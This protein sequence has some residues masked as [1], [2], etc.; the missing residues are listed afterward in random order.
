VDRDGDGTPDHQDNCG[1]TG[2]ILLA[3]DQA[4]DDADGI[5]DACDD[6]PFKGHM[7]AGETYFY[8][9]YD[10]PLSGFGEI[11]STLSVR[12]KTQ[13]FKQDYE[14][15]GKS[16]LTFI[17]YQATFRV[18]YKPGGGGIVSFGSVHG[19]ASYARIPWDWKGNDP[20]YPYGVKTSA[21]TV[22]FHYRGSAAVCIFSRGCGPTK[23]PWV[24]IT[25]RDNN[26]MEVDAGVV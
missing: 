21:H 23:H 5:G 22:A 17:T 24:T 2:T 3:N 18:C 11:E 26:T 4:D 9:G 13:M 25:F 8:P 12:C 7:V 16:W 10:G 6:T 14:Q 1:K 19:D 20:G 15:F